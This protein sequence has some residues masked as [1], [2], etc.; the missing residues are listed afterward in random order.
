MPFPCIGAHQDLR[1]SLSHLVDQ[2]PTAAGNEGG[3]SLHR[4]LPKFWELEVLLGG[5]EDGA[6]D[7]RKE[8]VL[9]FFDVVPY[10]TPLPINNSAISFLHPP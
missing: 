6:H 7:A 5:D 9:Q 8:G 3:E 1:D 10:V 4:A 2:K